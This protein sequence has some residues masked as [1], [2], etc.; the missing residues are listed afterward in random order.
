MGLAAAAVVWFCAL[1]FNCLFWVLAAREW[2]LNRISPATYAYTFSRKHYNLVLIGLFNA[3]NGIFVVYSSSATRVPTALQPILLQ[4]VL[5]FTLVFSKPLLH[6]KWVLV[7]TLPPAPHHC[8]ATPSPVLPYFTA[9]VYVGAVSWGC[10]YSGRQ[11]LGCLVVLLSILV[12]FVPTFVDLAQ[13]KSSAHFESG[14]WW[15][16]VL[17]LACLPAALMNIYE[18]VRRVRVD[19]VGRT[20]WSILA[21]AHP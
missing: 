9:V 12:F 7:A 5:P 13:G 21:H 10:R 14:W 4:A 8:L 18:E 3:L 11:L 20:G 15:P 16:M 1:L 17:V 19:V 2:K 6:K